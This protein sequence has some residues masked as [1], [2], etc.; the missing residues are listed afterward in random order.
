MHKV[1]TKAAAPDE[2]SLEQKPRQQSN[3][4]Y[5][6]KPK[7]YVS[8]LTLLGVWAYTSL[9]YCQMQSTRDQLTLAFP[10]KLSVNS[11]HIWEKG[12]GSPQNP[13][14][15]S[16]PLVPGTEIEGAVLAVNYGREV[17][18]IAWSDCRAFWLDH[19][20]MTN[21]LWGHPKPNEIR[22]F[23][24]DP[25]YDLDQSIDR[26]NEMRPGD[27]ERWAFDTKVPNDV[28]GKELFVI[29]YVVYHDRLGT[30]RGVY[31]A[32][33]YDPGR[34]EFYPVDDKN[35]ENIEE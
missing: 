25:P 22:R 18:T 9:T 27:I 19:L 21:P 20:Q 23:S 14:N 31:F 11:I 35:Y 34:S 32:R 26:Q 24:G 16:P 4:G 13:R 17:A 7:N 10:P 6:C 5:F 29:G 2:S 12:K 30:R 3:R 33:K 1:S 15:T 8:L 28:V